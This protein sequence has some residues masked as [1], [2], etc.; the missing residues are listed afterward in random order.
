MID[1]SPSRNQEHDGRRIEKVKSMQRGTAMKYYLETMV[2][3]LLCGC[4]DNV[5]DSSSLNH[6]MSETNQS[7][8]TNRPSIIGTSVR[9]PSPWD[10]EQ[11]VTLVEVEGHRFAVVVVAG[12][13]VAIC[14]V[15]EASKTP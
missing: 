13:A 12:R 10:S 14:E 4:S 5:L 1:A 6:H 8:T 15:T 7:V 11:R 9:I 3:V 2:A